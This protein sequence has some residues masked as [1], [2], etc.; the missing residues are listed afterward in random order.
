MA[1]VMTGLIP[2]VVPAVFL[3]LE[4]LF[5]FIQAVVFTVLCLAYF[6]LNTTSHHEEHDAA[7]NLLPA[8]A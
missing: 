2:L 5:G 6:T 3:V 1:T 4:T 8:A 7:E